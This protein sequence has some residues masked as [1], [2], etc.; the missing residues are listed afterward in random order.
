MY[1]YVSKTKLR[2]IDINSTSPR[3]DEVL[4]SLIQDASRDF[5]M[6]CGDRVFYPQRDT[7]TLDLR[8]PTINSSL[9]LT[10]S[11]GYNPT[12][13]AKSFYW[14]MSLPDDLAKV[15]AVYINGIELLPT[16][17]ILRSGALYSPPFSEIDIDPKVTLRIP[18]ANPLDLRRPQIEIDGYWGYLSEFKNHF[19]DSLCEIIDIEG[20]N[21]KVSNSLLDDYNSMSA[22][23]ALDTMKMYM[24][25]E[26]YL[27]AENSEIKTRY[28]FIYF[29][30]EVNRNDGVF[31]VIR[32]YSNSDVLEDIKGKKL[33]EFTAVRG[34]EK[35]VRRLS[36]WYYRQK[37]SSTPDFDRP[38]VTQAGI[39]M[40]AKIPNDVQSVVDNYIRVGGLTME[41]SGRDFMWAFE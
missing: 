10:D 25:S 15:V 34:V 5:E 22:S 38:I 7:K 20:N 17:Y 24:V 14:R 1:P 36:A 4:I 3:Q 37:N 11:I 28:E 6:L 23:P 39:I 9:F 32:G 2:E 18:N 13:S 40:P 33:Y 31:R 27:D 21:I 12:F 19:V 30:A 26:E 41:T 16:E 29:V 35:A 8:R